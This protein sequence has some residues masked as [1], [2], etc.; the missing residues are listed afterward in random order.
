MPPDLDRLLD[1]PLAVD[2]L[3]ALGARPRTFA[4]LRSDF[5]ARRRDL[6]AA[7]R[8]L[9]AYGLVRRCGQPGT[10]DWCAPL[11]VSYELTGKGRHLAGELE[12][13]DVW[14]RVYERYLAEPG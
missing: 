7:L 14:V 10:W 8:V 1:H 3:D 12:D 13:L 6:D 9:A 5:R 4:G 11:S 2:V